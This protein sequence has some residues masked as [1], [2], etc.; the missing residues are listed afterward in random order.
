MEGNSIGSIIAHAAI[1]LC[2]KNGVEIHEGDIISLKD[3]HCKGFDKERPHL[4]CYQ[5]GGFSPFSIAH[6]KDEPKASEVE[7]I[8]N[9]YDNPDMDYC[10]G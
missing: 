6:W 9:K 10:I 2:D 1:G 3:S 4:V 7:I 5:N 8:G